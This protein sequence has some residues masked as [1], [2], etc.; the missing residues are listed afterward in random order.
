MNKIIKIALIASLIA[1]FGC[2]AEGNPSGPRIADKSIQNPAGNNPSDGMDKLLKELNG[3]K[4]SS[5][6]S[7]KESGSIDSVCDTY[8]E[9]CSGVYACYDDE[10]FYSCKSSSCSEISESSA[11]SACGFEY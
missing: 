1:L 10:S 9:V 6:S 3:G 4:S 8:V 11:M 2:S 5:P 7:K